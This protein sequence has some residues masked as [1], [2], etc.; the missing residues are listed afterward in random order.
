MISVKYNNAPVC[1]HYEKGRPSL[2]FLSVCKQTDSYSEFILKYFLLAF[3]YWK[4]SYV[5]RKLR[6]F[7]GMASHLLP[8]NCNV[9]DGPFPHV[10]SLTCSTYGILNCRLLHLF[11][12]MVAPTLLRNSE[13][14]VTAPKT[15]ISF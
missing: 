8:H 1:P 11:K 3:F 2:D 7:V 15:M 4:R 12:V 10:T 5:R 9:C 13:N 14:W 6:F